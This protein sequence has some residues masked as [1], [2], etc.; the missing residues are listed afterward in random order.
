MIYKR[1]GQNPYDKSAVIFREF[2]D[3]RLPLSEINKKIK[4][5]LYTDNLVLS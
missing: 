4:S 2:V 1:N 3:K 5:S